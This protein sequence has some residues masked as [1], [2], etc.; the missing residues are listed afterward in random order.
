MDTE[1]S[2]EKLR[3]LVLDWHNRKVGFAIRDADPTE[4]GALGGGL[5]LF[6]DMLK[7]RCETG[8]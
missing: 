4:R 7:F 5:S 2:K 1:S 3:K 6:P 8:W